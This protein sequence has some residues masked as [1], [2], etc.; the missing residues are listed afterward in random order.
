MHISQSMQIRQTDRT[1]QGFTF[2]FGVKDECP[3]DTDDGDE[4]PFIEEKNLRRIDCIHVTPVIRGCL[5]CAYTAHVA[6]ADHKAVHVTCHPPTA[7]YHSS[8]TYVCKWVTTRRGVEKNRA[9]VAT[10]VQVWARQFSQGATNRLVQAIG[11]AGG[12][13]KV[14]LPHMALVKPTH[15]NMSI[16]QGMGNILEM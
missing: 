5:S 12:V 3:F 8:E 14:T 11:V 13:G 15:R 2:G 16:T 10:G 7:R 6:K 9:H 1:P 4:E